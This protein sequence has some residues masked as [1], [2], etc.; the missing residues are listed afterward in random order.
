M[1]MMRCGGDAFVFRMMKKTIALEVFDGDC[2][3]TSILI[4]STL[5]KL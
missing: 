3:V 1:E 5:D 2:V 4:R